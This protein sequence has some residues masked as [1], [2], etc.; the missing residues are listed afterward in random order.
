MLN[1]NKRIRVEVRLVVIQAPIICHLPKILQ[2]PI[3]QSLINQSI[4]IQN[5]LTDLETSAV[6]VE[7]LTRYKKG[8]GK[9]ADAFLYVGI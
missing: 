1:L 8:T 9:I 4:L 6:A 7:P 2:S 5:H 3:D